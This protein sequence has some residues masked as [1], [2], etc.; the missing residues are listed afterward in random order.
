MSHLQDLV[1]KFNARGESPACL[2][3]SVKNCEGTGITVICRVESRKAGTGLRK[4]DPWAM[5]FVDFL[6]KNGPL[7][8]VI[9]LRV[10]LDSR[11]DRSDLES[12]RRRLSYLAL[13]NEWQVSLIVDRSTEN[14]YRTWDEL[15]S[16]PANEV[17][18]TE[19][20]RRQDSPDSDGKVE[21][22]FQTWLAGKNRSNNE[23]L[24]VL[25]VDFIPDTGGDQ[26]KVLREFPI[27]AF[28]L[29]IREENRLFPT[30]WIDFVTLNKY[31]ELSLIELKVGD[32]KLEVMA[33]A[34][35]YALFFSC[36]RILLAGFLSNH[37][38]EPKSPIDPEIPITCYIANNRFHR[39]FSGIAPYYAPT[40]EK[41]PFSFRRID[42]GNTSDLEP[43][44]KGT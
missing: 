27:G 17:V 11:P 23:R 25:G 10:E 28:D 34:L 5:A 32:V 19:V 3:F 15:L 29:E 1:A 40:L 12:F 22:N 8:P 42:L 38:L 21:K 44:R 2:N 18:Y 37:L 14:L 43:R 36:Y 24:A 26:A 4:V 9:G 41:P 39:C 20:N 30:Y 7:Q 35:D 13:N 6:E 31:R 16:R 33:Q